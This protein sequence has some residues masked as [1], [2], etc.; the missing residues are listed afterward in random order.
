MEDWK[1]IPQY[2]AY[3]AS[4]LGNIRSNATKKVL[5]PYHVPNGYSQVRLSLGSKTSYKLCRVHRLV[6]ETWIPN[7]DPA[8]TTVNHKNRDKTDNC[9]NNLEWLSNQEQSQHLASSVDYTYKRF[10]DVQTSLDGECWTIIEKAPE[11]S[12]SNM[13]R[14]K[15]NHI[16]RVL[17]GH[18]KTVYNQV[19]LRTPQQTYKTFYIHK[20]VAEAF[21]QDYDPVLVVNHRDG[22]KKNNSARNLEC[23]TQS[24]NIRHAYESGQHRQ[25]V[26]IKQ[27]SLCGEV[28]QEYKSFMSAARATGLKEGTIRWA[29]KYNKPHGG[30]LWSRSDS[31]S[32]V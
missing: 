32:Q 31:T 18:T 10:A 16:D 3:E 27:H 15:I 4:T 19:K 7:S 5:K 17:R 22:D 2:P 29:I 12:V 28:M 8:R 23:I 13:G 25:Q 1:P 6:A 9:I 26:S 11:Y 30:F 21:L 24:A 20:L 14:V